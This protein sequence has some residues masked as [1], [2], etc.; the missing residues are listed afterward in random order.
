M[1]RASRKSNSRGTC[2]RAPPR[3]LA[4]QQSSS[5]IISSSEQQGGV[6]PRAVP[7]T[8]P[9][10]SRS[11]PGELAAL[12]GGGEVQWEPR[13][14]AACRGGPVGMECRGGVDGDGV[15]GWR[16]G[17]WMVY[18]GARCAGGWMDGVCRRMD[19]VCWEVSR[20]GPARCRCAVAWQV[21]G[22]G[23]GVPKW[24]EAGAAERPAGDKRRSL[25]GVL[26]MICSAGGLCALL[27]AGCS[28]RR[29]TRE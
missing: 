28:A 16:A 9:W 12:P 25:R 13:C 14:G 1:I 19:G 7:P 18:A 29:T 2:V 10:R 26:G 4:R 15:P 22:E 11:L 3:R 6:E 23:Q 27:G 24:M 20:C 21:Q 17:G 8:T 5:A